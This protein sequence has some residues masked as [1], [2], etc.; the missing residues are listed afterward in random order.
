MRHQKRK[1]DQFSQYRVLH[2]LA[3]ISRRLVRTGRGW[4]I[5]CFVALG[6]K[7]Y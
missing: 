4:G 3:N 1:P 7:Y 6:P 2:K 5:S